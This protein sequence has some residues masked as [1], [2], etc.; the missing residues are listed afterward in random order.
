MMVTDSNDN[1]ADGIDEVLTRYVDAYVR[2]E[3]P[4]IDEFVKQYPEHETKIRRR[5][6]NLCEIDS[7]FDS[8]VQTGQN[9]FEGDDLVGQKVGDFEIIEIIG[10]GGMGVVYR[11]HDTKLDRT[12][13]IKSIPPE[14]VGSSTAR[15][16]FRREAKLLASLNNPNIAVIH[17]IIEGEKSGYLVLE[18]V[19]GQTLSERI[20]HEPLELEEAL[21]ISQQIAE[22]V[23]A[24][25]QKGIVHRD[26][27]PGNIKITPE[28]K[29]KVLDFGLAKTCDSDHRDSEIAATHPGRV[30]GTPVYMSPEQARGKDT[31]YRTD[32]WSFGCIMYQML[33][34][35]LP[36]EGETA[37]DTL[38]KIIER[39]PDWKA[40]P[41]ETPTNIRALLQNCLEKDSDRRLSDINQAVI[42]IRE[43][44]SKSQIA[45]AS[46]SRRI[47]MIVGA[48]A[49]GII[50][51]VSALKLIPQK[52]TQPSS[53]PIRLVVLP[54]ENLGLDDDEY[55]AD[56]ITDEI[57]ARLAGIPGLGVISRLSAMRY[58][59]KNESPQQIAQELNVDYILEGTIQRERPSDPNSKVRIRPQ[60]IKAADDTHIWADS[61]DNYMSEIFHL[62]SEVAERVARA[63][64]ITLLEP[65]RKLIT[66]KATE[67]L[68]AYEYYLKGKEYYLLGSY[69]VGAADARQS[70][71]MFKKA[72]ELD[73]DFA[74]AHAQLSRV[75]SWMYRSIDNSD[76]RLQMAKDALQNAFRIDPDLPEAYHARGVFYFYCHRNLKLAL[77][78]Y[79][80]VRK[81][82]PNNSEILAA[83]SH[84][85]QRQG[86]FEEALA[87]IKDAFDLNPLFYT[88]AYEV[89]VNLTGFREYAEA[90]SYH[91]RA[92]K[93]A[94]HEPSPYKG[95][96]GNHMLWQG[97]TARA[98][99]I[100][101]E[102]LEKIEPPEKFSIVN[103]LISIDIYERKYEHAL[104]RLSSVPDDFYRRI[105]RTPKVLKR[106]L[107]YDYWDKKELAK[108]HYELA[109]SFLK[110][111]INEQPEES[112]LHGMLGIAYAGLGREQEALEKGEFSVSIHK[113][114]V[115]KLN[116]IKNLAHIYAMLE[117]PKEA[118][119]KL[120]YLL[121]AT[122]KLI[123]IPLLKIDPAWEPIKEHPRFKKLI[124]S[125]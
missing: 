13:A 88:Y 77:E 73:P 124:D 89:G 92:I 84:V 10:R 15:V 125:D 106:A 26:L 53:N 61:Y 122:P 83:I 31:D 50:L 93:L 35:L 51:S 100:L 49:I 33:T 4:D 5:I 45:P 117:K 96:A 91:E 34:G 37:T 121:R 71:E 18:Y 52:V 81:S 104:D 108:E 36:F 54:F 25:H 46:K 85:Q 76:A 56:G 123:S 48:V 55:F 30:I 107:I 42:V 19:P 59:K 112:S 102:A 97:D 99:E 111:K 115:G 24:A 8:L 70:I 7:L 40:L 72:I 43:T 39:Q 67:N 16:R 94:P 75:H 114:P 21:L 63:L 95:K 113:F 6:E 109:C 17:E 119:D 1:Q 103:Q 64:D 101:E 65:Q 38:A 12:V 32:I 47:A 90:D 105:G 87:N 41:Q 3:K 86:K 82:Q 2:D 80:I 116:R 9:D 78:Q 69:Q 20:A 28:G 60:L 66:Y 120:D 14:L 23:L 57:T 79:E 62:Q 98:R 68:Q 11:A 27:K 118:I 58:K 74:Q 110:N 29:V 44:L 22:A